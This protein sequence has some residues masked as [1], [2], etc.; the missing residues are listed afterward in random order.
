MEAFQLMEARWLI[1]LDY[2][3]DNANKQQ[4]EQTNQQHD[5]KKNLVYNHNL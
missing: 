2:K 4:P 1:I 3:P 5:A